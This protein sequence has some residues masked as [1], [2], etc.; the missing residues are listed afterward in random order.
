MSD[1]VDKIFRKALEEVTVE[2]PARVWEAIDAHF[3]LKQRRQ[4]RLFWYGGVAAAAALLLASGLVVRTG[5][6]EI[7]PPVPLAAS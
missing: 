1:S 7:R 2:P 6:S 5:S 3:A 4:R